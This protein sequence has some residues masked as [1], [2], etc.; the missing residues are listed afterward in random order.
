MSCQFVLRDKH[1]AGKAAFHLS[2]QAAV[3]VGLSWPRGMEGGLKG[4]RHI[5]T[6][7]PFSAELPVGTTGSFH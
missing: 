7:S 3:R 6:Y 4:Q 1:I 2:D 5:I